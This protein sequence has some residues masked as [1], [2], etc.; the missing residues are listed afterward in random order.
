MSGNADSAEASGANVDLVESCLGRLS[1][2]FPM[3]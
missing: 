1:A 2:V 3:N